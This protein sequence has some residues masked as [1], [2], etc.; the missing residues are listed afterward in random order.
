MHAAAVEGHLQTIQLLV[1]RDDIDVNLETNDGRTALYFASLDGKLQCVQELLEHGADAHVKNQEGKT[2]LDV[3]L[4][5][6]RSQDMIAALE[7]VLKDPPPP[8][9]S[10]SSREVD[11][12]RKK[13][14][15]ENPAVKAKAE[16]YVPPDPTQWRKTDFGKWS[17]VKDEDWEAL[18]AHMVCGDNVINHHG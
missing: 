15:G 6:E 14:E 5:F 10:K 9:K 13:E 12:G 16:A 7:S 2:A 4:L 17:R 11:A 8:R 18:E 3:A 1:G